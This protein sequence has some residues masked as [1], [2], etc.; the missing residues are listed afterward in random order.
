MDH[1]GLVFLL[2]SFLGVNKLFHRSGSSYPTTKTPQRLIQL[3]HMIPL[4]DWTKIHG[5]ISECNLFYSQVSPY[6]QN[7][8]NS[9]NVAGTLSS[10]W[11]TLHTHHFKIPKVI[12]H[13]LPHNHSKNPW[14]THHLPCVDPL[15]KTCKTFRPFLTL[16]TQRKFK[17]QGSYDPTNLIKFYP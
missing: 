13:E 10:G 5:K 11:N 9:H 16:L 14:H 2:I 3:F 7:P 8:Q 15:K 6:S 4:R 1:K 17:C 12:K